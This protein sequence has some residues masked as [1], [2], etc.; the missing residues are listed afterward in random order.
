LTLNHDIASPFIQANKAERKA[1][2]KEEKSLR[3]EE[4]K[5]AVSLPEPKMGLGRR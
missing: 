1:K 4:K 3:R 2:S 5:L